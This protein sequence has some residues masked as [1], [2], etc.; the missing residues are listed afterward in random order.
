[1][2]R[3]SFLCTA[4]L[5]LVTAAALEAQTPRIAYIDSQAILQEA[6]GA[7]E[8]QLEFE[9]DLE[10]YQAEVE[11]MGEEMD[12]LIDDYQQQQSALSEEDRQA[13]EEEIQQKEMEY[14]QRLEELEVLADERRREL[15]EPILDRMSDTIEEIRAE[16]EYTMIFDLASRAIIAADPELDLTSEVIERLQADAESEDR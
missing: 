5:L 14:Q 2:Y 11:E 3:R 12:Q 9:S 1:M 7:T 15:V 8:A 13:R 10:T 6:P 16:G 4:F